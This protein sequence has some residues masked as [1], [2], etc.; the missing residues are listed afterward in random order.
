MLFMDTGSYLID[1][2]LVKVDR[3]SMA[4]SLEVRCP[5]LDYRLVE[6][7]WRFRTCAKTK[8]GV[9]KLPLRE[10]LDRYVPRPLIE[11]PKRGFGAPVG[12]LA[13]Q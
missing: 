7:S 9:G 2:I 12:V 5:L 4:A 6:L 10:V 1:D 3:A 8:D 13:P 11:R